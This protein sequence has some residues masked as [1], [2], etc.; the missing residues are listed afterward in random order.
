MNTNTSDIDL[1]Y[2]VIGYVIDSIGWCIAMA[3][4]MACSSFLVAIIVGIVM[5]ILMYMLSQVVYLF[6]VTKVS[7]ERAA[8]IGHTVGGLSARFTNLFA[9]KVT[10]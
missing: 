3:A 7:V 9:K 5:S 10:A 1:G 4:A 2:T 6:T 8:S